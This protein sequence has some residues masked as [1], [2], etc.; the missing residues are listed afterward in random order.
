MHAPQIAEADDLFKSLKR[1]F[2]GFAGSDFITGCQRVRRIETDAYPA[3][4]LHLIDD[5]CQ[6][7]KSMSQVAP[8][9]GRILQ[10]GSHPVGTVESHVD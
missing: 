2:V 10:H 3:F 6:L 7:F 5:V 1:I 4:V 9:T 8:L